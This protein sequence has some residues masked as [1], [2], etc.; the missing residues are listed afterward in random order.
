MNIKI[1]EFYTTVGNLIRERRNRRGL[2]QEALAQSL[3]PKM[4]RVS[5]A[6]IESGNQRI[7]SHTLFQ[8]AGVL[9]VPMSELLPPKEGA[10]TVNSSDIISE[11]SSK[12]GISKSQAKKIAKQAT[13]PNAEDEQ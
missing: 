13:S 6:N 3:L 9:D 12:L 7:L 1:E 11:L 4:T 8:I 2:T 10:I 5:I